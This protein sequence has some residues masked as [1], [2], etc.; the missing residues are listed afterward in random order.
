MIASRKLFE[1]AKTIRSKNAGVDKVTFDVIFPDR[2]TYDLVRESG[3]LSRAA[4][5]RILVSTRRK[6]PITSSSIRHWRSSSRHTVGCRAAAQETAMSSAAN[7]MVHCS[8]LKFR[9]C[10]NAMRALLGFSMRR[11]PLEA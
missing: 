6:P 1:V 4:V 5:C 11:P 7:N 8:T 3:I 9:A 2:A 10:G